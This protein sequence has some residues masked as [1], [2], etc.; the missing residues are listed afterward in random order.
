MELGLRSE[1]DG[2]YAD[3]ILVPIRT[4]DLLCWAWQVS[5]GM[6]FLGVRKVRR[7]LKPSAYTFKSLRALLS[8][9]FQV[10]H[11]DLAARN[12][13]LA[14]NNV[15]KI[16]DLGLAKALLNKDH[17]NKEEE[18]PLPVK[19]MAIEALRERRFS[20]ESDIWSFG[21]VL[22]EFF[23]L[24]QSPYPE[25]YVGHIYQKLVDG[26]RLDKPKYAPKNMQV[27]ATETS[28][29]LIQVHHVFFYINFRY[30]LMMNCWDAEPS[31]RPSFKLIETLIDELLDDS[32]KGV[33]LSSIK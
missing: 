30:R 22:W 21:V 10:V 32:V 9:V 14:D 13:L 15:I 20:I 18:E 3:N 5:R 11:G 19:W 24:A 4:R 28:L 33:S 27:S 7:N 2:D 16:C 23:T 12:I 29:D 31:K 6:R 26:Y 17:Y 1:Y 8:N 25:I